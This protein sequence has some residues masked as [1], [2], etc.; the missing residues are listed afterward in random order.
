MRYMDVAIACEADQQ[1]ARRSDH[2]GSGSQG[3]EA[4]VD[5]RARGGHDLRWKEMI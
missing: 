5:Q 1:Q 3:L 2:T 4:D